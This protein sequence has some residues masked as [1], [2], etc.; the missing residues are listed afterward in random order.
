MNLKVEIISECQ[1]NKSCLVLGDQCLHHWEEDA[2]EDDVDGDEEDDE[3]TSCRSGT[4]TW[5]CWDVFPDV[6]NSHSQ[7][8][9]SVTRLSY[10]RM[11][12]DFNF[13]RDTLWICKN[14]RNFKWI[15]V[16]YRFQK[17]LYWPEDTTALPS[18]SRLISCSIYK[19]KNIVLNHVD[20]SIGF[21]YW[22]LVLKMPLC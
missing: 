21:Y 20:C 12:Q 6:A 14:E 15:L 11:K 1:Y 16:Y 19:S 13:F 5:T 22:V 4:G 9:C 17:I 3:A 18:I 2:L 7:A 10:L 8:Y